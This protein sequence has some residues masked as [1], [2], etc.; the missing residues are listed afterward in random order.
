MADLTK[1]V[2]PGYE[3]IYFPPVPVPP[4]TEGSLNMVRPAGKVILSAGFLFGAG[5]TLGKRD[6]MVIH[7]SGPLN[8]SPPGTTWFIGGTNLS[9]ETISLQGWLLVCDERVG[10]I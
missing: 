8:T 3:I 4:N 10:L 6:K 9:D 2:L 7:T 5:N 1:P